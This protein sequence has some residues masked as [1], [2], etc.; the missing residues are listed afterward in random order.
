MAIALLGWTIIAF[1]A[2]GIT[3]SLSQKDILELARAEARTSIEKDLLYRRWNAGFG[4]VYVPI[5]GDTQPNPYLSLPERDITT[6]SGR[7]LTLVNPAYMVR[8]VFQ[9]QAESGIRSHITSLKPINPGNAADAWEADALRN[10]EA[11]APEVSS[12]EKMDGQAY[13]RLMRPLVTEQ[14]CLNCHASQGYKVGDVRGGI[15]VSIPMTRYASVQ[16]SFTNNIFLGYGIIWLVGLLG[17]VATFHSIGK[18]M[19]EREAIA[20]DALTSEARLRA[21]GDNLMDTALYVYVLDAD[22]RASFEYASAGIEFL[23]GISPEDAIADPQKLRDVILP[24]YRAQ[25]DAME[26]TSREEL[27]RFEM[28]F[29]QKHA[30]TGKIR[31]ILLRA[32]PYRRLNGA[33]YWY[34]VLVD[35]T[36][37]KQSENEV[38]IANQQLNS[39]LREVENLHEELIE[40]ALRDPL[41]GLHN[42]RFLL[43]FTK[44]G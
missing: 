27:T 23:T 24:E 28:E 7:R 2:M 10:F 35:I 17:I 20:A 16:R 33:T 15:S 12:V 22:G 18:L 14:G 39:T 6:P 38:Q 13:M 5:M 37:R 30:I 11:G 21:I 8:Q 34:T 25:L 42:R 31:W 36:A 19:M 3:W 4:G 41:T 44:V 40:Q 1:A 43:T 26:R 32:T 29:Q 9:L